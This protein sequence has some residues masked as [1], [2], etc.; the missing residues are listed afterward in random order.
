MQSGSQHVFIY[1][2]HVHATASNW[3]NRWPSLQISLRVEYVINTTVLGAYRSLAEAA[4][5]SID[6]TQTRTYTYILM[7]QRHKAQGA[8]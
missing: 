5:V 4:G 3:G 2:Q 1:L 6:Y 8:G 7:L